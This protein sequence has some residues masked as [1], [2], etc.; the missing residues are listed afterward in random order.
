MKKY[1]AEHKNIKHFILVGHSK[2]ATEALLA[3]DP[4]DVVISLSGRYR[5]YQNAYARY[6]PSEIEEINS[7]GYITKDFWGL[8]M[9][10][11][12]ESFDERKTL[13]ET[14]LSIAK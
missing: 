11:T 4:N 12:K 5:I 1:Y 14:I 10:V 3:A 13:E 8:K 6:S 7:V 9:K 2:G